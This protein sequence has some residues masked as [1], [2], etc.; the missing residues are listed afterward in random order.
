MILVP[1][2]T[3]Q[4]KTAEEIAALIL[5]LEAAQ[6]KRIV[7]ANAKSGEVAYPWHPSE[8]PDY[9]ARVLTVASGNRAWLEG[10]D[11]MLEF[12]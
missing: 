4:T 7:I 11:V 9:L 10:D 3:P 6:P 8:T 5:T 12:V 2:A 1:K